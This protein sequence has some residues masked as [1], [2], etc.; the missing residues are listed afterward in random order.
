MI[1]VT[2]VLLAATIIA[3]IEVP[4]LLKKKLMKELCF[5]SIILLVGTAVCIAHVLKMNVPNPLDWIT[6][7]YKPASDVIFGFINQ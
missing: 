5:F 6:V 2:G 1:A 3:L 4:S 7:I